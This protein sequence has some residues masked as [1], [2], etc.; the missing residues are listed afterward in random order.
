MKKE[1]LAIISLAILL[2]ASSI[3]NVILEIRINGRSPVSKN[4]LKVGKAETAAPAVLDPVDSWD[5]ISNDMIRHVC[6]TLFVYD[7]TDPALP[8]IMRVATN[9]SWNIGLDEL[10]VSLRSDVWFHDGVK[11]NATAVKFTFDRLTYFMNVSGT[12]PKTSH[13]CDPFYLFLDMNKD[14]ILNRTEIIDEY[15]VRFILNKP[16]GVFIS[17]LSDEASSIL[18]PK[19]TPATEYLEFAEEDILVGTGPFEYNPIIFG[20]ELRFTRFDLY[21]GLATFWEEIIWVFYPDATTA[22]YAM[23]EQNFDYLGSP[24]T[25]LIPEFQADEDI[26]VVEMNTSTIFRYWS[27]NNRKINNTYVRK[28]IAYA[29]NYT[30]FIKEIRQGFAIKAEQFLPPGFPHYNSSF[31]A[32]YYN[33]AIARQAMM[34]AFPTETAAAGVTAEAVG[35]NPTNDALWQGL[36]LATYDVLKYPGYTTG[37]MMNEAFRQ[38]MEQIGIVIVP[39][40]PCWDPWW[41]WDWGCDYDE[42]KLEIFYSGWRPDYIDPFNMLEPLLNNLSSNHL[43]NNDYLIHKWLKQYEETDPT[44]ITGRSKLIY[45]IQQRAINELYLLIPLG[46]DHTLYVHHRS[47]GGVSYNIQRNLWLT[48][49]YFIPGISKA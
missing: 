28:A 20:E 3:V 17:L 31:N 11:F 19:S 10:T 34:T 13:V 30:Y 43:R 22:S 48:D 32:P 14:P 15:T 2:T 38:D 45:K 24:L 37:I 6:D 46:F 18:H 47:L 9:Y 36:T 40:H 39:D 21:W 23:L 7:L 26:V 8:L 41:G 5:S 42:D 27:L 44:N 16:N 12:L 25:S 4:V 1:N 35:V 33:T 49:S 29:Y